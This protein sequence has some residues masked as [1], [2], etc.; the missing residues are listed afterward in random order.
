MLN[1]LGA[2]VCFALVVAYVWGVLLAGRRAV[3]WPILVF[4]VLFGWCWPWTYPRIIAVGLGIVWSA[5]ALDIVRGEARDPR[6]LRSLPTLLFWLVIPPDSHWPNDVVAA[7]A[8]RRRGQA[9]LLRALPKGVLLLLLLGV[10]HHWPGLHDHLLLASQWSLWMIFAG[11]SGLADVVTG[12]AMQTGIDVDETFDAPYLARSPRDFWAHRW[13][14]YIHEFARR[15]CF[16][17][18]GGQRRPLQV[19]LATFAASGLMHEYFVFACVG[20]VPRHFGWMMT[21]F[22]LHGVAVVAEVVAR[23]LRWPKLPR[24]TA[25]TLHYAWM[26]LTAPLFAEPLAEVFLSSGP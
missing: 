9:R 20:G 21:Y 11:V 3:L 23:R 4:A 2:S 7:R 26:V 16:R 18:W 10:S 22:V 5:K 8:H 15:H 1:L 13:N 25:I 12:L 24:R 19:T 17:Q 6:M 14:L